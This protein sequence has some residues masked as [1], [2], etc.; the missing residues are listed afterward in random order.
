MQ[1]VLWIRH[2]V[3][4]CCYVCGM[5]GFVVEFMCVVMYTECMNS[6][7]SSC[8]LL[9]TQNE[10]IRRRVHACCYVYRMNRFVVEFMCVVMYT[11]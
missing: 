11:E 6:S 2:R 8:V 1:N 5:Y 9:Y 10:R 4:L 3:H 7:S